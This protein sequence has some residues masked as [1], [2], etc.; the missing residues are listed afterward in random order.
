MIQMHFLPKIDQK[1]QN[2]QFLGKSMSKSGKAVKSGNF[3]ILAAL[4][5]D[6]SSSGGIWKFGHFDSIVKF[7]NC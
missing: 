4:K 2:W 3:G 5:L 6:I 7:K 1:S